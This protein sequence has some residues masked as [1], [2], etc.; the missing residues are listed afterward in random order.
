MISGRSGEYYRS[1][2]AKDLPIYFNHEEDNE[3]QVSEARLRAGQLI[4]S[5][6]WPTSAMKAS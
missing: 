5:H 4:V 6:T 1:R 2:W 3:W